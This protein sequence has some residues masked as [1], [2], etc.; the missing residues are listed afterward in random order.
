[1]NNN[2]NDEMEIIKGHPDQNPGPNQFILDHIGG[3]PL[4]PDTFTEAKPRFLPMYQELLRI[5]NLIEDAGP[6]AIGQQIQYWVVI[7]GRE[8]GLYHTAAEA[9]A[10][11]TNIRN[12]IWVSSKMT[13][14]EKDKIEKLTHDPRETI[15]ERTRFQP[16]TLQY[17]WEF[18]E[19]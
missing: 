17:L 8:P 2:N 10:Q 1:M 16:G 18:L 3:M 11:I 7:I 9:Q 14:I 5:V 4:G 15:E 19:R 12:G 13:A 6:A